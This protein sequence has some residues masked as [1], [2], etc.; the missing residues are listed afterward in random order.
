MYHFQGQHHVEVVEDDAVIIVKQRDF[1]VLISNLPFFLTEGILDI[2]TQA[3]D[4]GKPFRRAVMSVH[5]DDIFSKWDRLSISTLCVL[6]QEDFHPHQPFLSKV[7]LV[8]PK[9]VCV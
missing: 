6:N 9:P 3:V 8:Q 4:S 5:N 1:G 7:I 2:L